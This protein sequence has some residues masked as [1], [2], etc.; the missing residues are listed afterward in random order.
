GSLIAAVLVSLAPLRF[1]DP[2]EQQGRKGR[3][4]VRRTT[5]DTEDAEDAEGSGTEV[6]RMA[7]SSLPPLCPLRSFLVVEKAL[8]R[9]RG[10]IVAGSSLMSPLGSSSQNPLGSTY[11]SG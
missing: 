11:E 6:M 10:S 8:G 5:E 4:D 7:R 3:K 9:G 1:S 2:E